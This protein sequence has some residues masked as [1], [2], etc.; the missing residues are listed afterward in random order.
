MYFVSCKPENFELML[1][2]RLFLLMMVCISGV[3]TAQDIQVAKRTIPYLASDALEGRFPGTPGDSMAMQ[4]IESE[5]EAFG[6][7]TFD[8]GYRQEFDIVTE[9]R[10]SDECYVHWNAQ[11]LE[12]SRDYLPLSYSGAEPLDA[13]V[14]LGTKELLKSEDTDLDGSWVLVLLDDDE[15]SIPDYRDMIDIGIQARLRDAGGLIVSYMF[16]VTDSTEFYPLQYN[17]SFAS[18]SLPAIQVSR[19]VIAESLEGCDAALSDVVMSEDINK[20]PDIDLQVDAQVKI[21]KFET[22]TANLAGWI[23]GDNAD[24]WIVVGAHYDHLGY[25]GYGSG[26]RTPERYDIHNGADDN[27]SG[28][29]SV[30]MLADHYAE[31]PPGVNI[32]FVLFG[33]EEQGLLGS[34]YFVDNMPFETDKVK[35]MLNFDMVGRMEDSVLSIIGTTTAEEYQDILSECD[36]DLLKLKLRKGGYSGSDQAVFYS[37]KLPVLFFFTGLNE[38]YHT[39]D[40]IESKINYEGIDMLCHL[41]VDLLDTLFLPETTLTY[42]EVKSS[43]KRKHGDKMKVKLG[44]MPDMTGESDNGMRVDAVISGGVADKSGL[45]KGDIITKI[46]DDEIE[47]IYDYMKIMSRFEEGSKTQ[48]VVIR[49]GESMVFDVKF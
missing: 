38:D 2:K 11:E 41:C 44:I 36:G 18:I 10:A 12:I 3:L 8:F 46:G 7:N 27:A 39:P 14:V 26:S 40:D 9:I 31:H 49:E 28:V 23:E 24:E 42:Q 17:R 21:D 20:V 29:A 15:G 22:T 6:L 13:D 5:F 4:F 30:L 33:A 35:T 37:E 32:A 48:I 1:L 43:K 45:L 19:D 25:G 34:K 47:N 16:D